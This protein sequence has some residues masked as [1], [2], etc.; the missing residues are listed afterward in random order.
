MMV[1]NVR[2]YLWCW[3]IV[4]SYLLQKYT[5]EDE[6]FAFLPDNLI[7]FRKMYEAEGSS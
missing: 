7:Y 3:Q 6:K 5:F 1:L 4:R 2:D